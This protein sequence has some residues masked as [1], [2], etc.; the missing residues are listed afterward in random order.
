MKFLGGHGGQVV[1]GLVGALVVE[2]VD[3]V[4]GLDLDVL[5][6][7][8]RAFGPDQLG[9]VEPDL[10]FGQRVVVGVAHRPDGRV[11]SFVDESLGEGEADVLGKFNQSMQHRAREVSVGVV[12]QLGQVGDA[13][14]SAR[15]DRVL[16]GVEHR[17]VVIR[18]AARQPTIRRE[19][20]SKT[21]AT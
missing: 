21:K 10:G 6:A 11:D 14:L 15:P 1:E 17:S 8:P 16:E 9:L 5:D 13:G 2:P 7:A 19:K 4:Q 18:V 12:D 3:V 20:T